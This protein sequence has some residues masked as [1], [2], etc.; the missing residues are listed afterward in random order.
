MSSQIE[1]RQLEQGIWGPKIDPYTFN[2]DPR[3][4]DI[5]AEAHDTH[6]YRKYDLLAIREI[7]S[8]MLGAG[9]DT[10]DRHDRTLRFNSLASNF[11][12]YIT[13]LGF[14][15]KGLGFT[16]TFYG[17]LSIRHLLHITCIVIL[18]EMNNFETVTKDF[19]VEMTWNEMSERIAHGAIDESI[20]A[21]ATASLW[22]QFCLMFSKGPKFAGTGDDRGA[23]SAVVVNESLWLDRG[24]TF[25][26]YERGMLPGC[27]ILLL[28]ISQMI[29][30]DLIPETRE[31]AFLYLQDLVL[32][33]YLIATPKERSILQAVFMITIQQNAFWELYYNRF[34][35]GQDC[36]ALR[37]AYSSLYATWKQ[38]NSS[39]SAVPIEL[40]SQMSVLVHGTV[41]LDLASSDEERIDVF[42]T[43]F[44]LLWLVLE[45]RKQIP[46]GDFSKVRDFGVTVFS[47]LRYERFIPQ[48]LGLARLLLDADFM[49]ISGR[50]ALLA[51]NQDGKLPDADKSLDLLVK[52]TEEFQDIFNGAILAVP[53]LLT[54]SEIEWSKICNQITNWVALQDGRQIRTNATLARRVDNMRLAWSGYQSIYAPKN[55]PQKCA[56]PRCA[57]GY[58]GT[59]VIEGYYTCG[60]CHAAVYCDGEYTGFC[61]L[62]IHINFIVDTGMALTNVRRV[63]ASIWGPEVDPRSFILHLDPPDFTKP[64]KNERH[65]RAHSV[66]PMGDLTGHLITGGLG[67]K[68]PREIVRFEFLVHNCLNYSA[69][70]DIPLE[71]I[72][73]TRFYYGFLAIRHM[74]HTTCI[75]I[76]KEVA[77][78]KIAR[79]LNFGDKWTEISRK[80]ASLALDEAV[81]NLAHLKSREQFCAIFLGRRF[82]TSLAEG[83]QCGTELN[84]LLWLD[85]ESVLILY[86]R[87]LLPGCALLLLA[88][89]NLILAV[90]NR[91]SIEVTPPLEREI[92]Q[93]VCKVIANHA[94]VWDV[95]FS[96]FYTIED[97]HLVHQ[98]FLELV[99]S[100]TQN[101][102]STRTVSVELIYQLAAFVRSVVTTDYLVA[103]MEQVDI[104]RLF[105]RALWIVFEH[106]RHIT[107]DDHKTVQKY[108]AIGICAFFRDLA[109][110]KDTPREIKLELAQ[111]IVREELFVLL[112][113]VVLLVTEG[114]S[115]RDHRKYQ[116]EGLHPLLEGMKVIP[117][118][119]RE[120]LPLTSEDL[121]DSR[122]DCAKVF[123]QLH[124]WG[125][126][127]FQHASSPMTLAKQVSNLAST[128]VEIERSIGFG[129]DPAECIYPRCSGKSTHE[130]TLRLNDLS[131]PQRTPPFI[132]AEPLE[133]PNTSFAR[134]NMSKELGIRWTP[135][136]VWGREIDPHSYSFDPEY[137]DASEVDDSHLYEQHR[138]LPLNLFERHLLLYHRSNDPPEWDDGFFDLLVQTLQAHIVA[139]KLPSQHVRVTASYYGF[140]CIRHFVHFVAISIL[141]ETRRF[142]RTRSLIHS[143]MRW[144]QASK[145]LAGAA[146]DITN[147]ALADAGTFPIFCDIFSQPRF[148]K[149]VS[150][151]VNGAALAAQALWDDRSAVLTLYKRGELPGCSLLLL[152][153]SKIVMIDP[154]HDE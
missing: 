45:H 143:E 29:L 125:Q 111:I 66:L 28:V 25:A 113:K 90:P 95:G 59:S 114:D 57:L 117:K 103:D 72:R 18:K 13:A 112:G 16:H 102:G 116:R 36:N 31:T 131:S 40:M 134:A 11:Y 152:A 137:S 56:Y 34:F 9:F 38:D 87:G 115:E 107:L 80:I 149:R 123:N 48:G 124:D 86:M 132:S 119:L 148:V 129:A 84:Y 8:H 26:L 100:W 60:K 104:L 55:R 92:I 89:L 6:L 146:I 32:R 7:M 121:R 110:P 71:D 21:L 39:S 4:A 83:A 19:N 22:K 3:M 78:E 135:D 96:R 118:V 44:R 133:V 94:N 120:T 54:R 50:I 79:S 70:L 35:S 97:S 150:N 128:W 130:D 139:L 93:H 122:I 142:E 136:P 58:T 69:A 37:Q 27:P 109:L 24:S 98:K 2:F 126:R 153:I 43:S 154:N 14:E 144:K 49:A 17:F 75:G 99:S 67:T 105:I 88:L 53:E 62:E 30:D 61:R 12:Q 85:R 1:R 15:S 41:V 47:A 81:K 51:L 106:R 141:K 5:Q 140:L 73:I 63:P 10:G 151:G 101:I 145:L 91:D 33:L 23:L 138:A 20:K 52:E 68:E 127:K 108:M 76:L 77:P 65:Y 74:V 46:Q 82:T 147:K 42:Q 64:D